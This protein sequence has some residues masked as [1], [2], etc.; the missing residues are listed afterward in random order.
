M[1]EPLESSRVW[2]EKIRTRSTQQE[3]ATGCWPAAG[4][5]PHLPFCQIKRF[6]PLLPGGGARDAMAGPPRSACSRCPRA[7][8]WK[9]AEPTCRSTR[10][11]SRWGCCRRYAAC[12]SWC[13][14]AAGRD[15]VAGLLRRRLGPKGEGIWHGMGSC[16]A[17]VCNHNG[18]LPAV[19]HHHA[20]HTIAG[21]AWAGLI[22]SPPPEGRPAPPRDT[23][24]LGR[25]PSSQEAQGIAGVHDRLVP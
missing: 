3:G 17:H 20:C 8:H 5:L 10:P 25:D 4:A 24:R 7:G 9:S 19:S 13:R 18:P 2:V 21:K 16:T 23:E 6:V 15:A 1:T 14:E 11:C 22:F 12:E